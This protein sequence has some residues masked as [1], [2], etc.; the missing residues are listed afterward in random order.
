PTP[1]LHSFPTRRSSDLTK[2]SDRR[3]KLNIA[4]PKTGLPFVL[5]IN[6]VA[7]A[8]ST[9]ATNILIATGLGIHNSLSNSGPAALVLGDE[10]VSR[11]EEHTSELQS[12]RDLV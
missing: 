5:D 2:S 12:R 4:G 10:D 9:G 1:H 6:T 7:L 8:D 3:G 11:S